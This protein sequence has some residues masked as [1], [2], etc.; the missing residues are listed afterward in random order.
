MVSTPM[1]RQQNRRLLSQLDDL[2]QDVN[3]GDGASSG[4]QNVVVNSG[5]VDKEFTVNSDDD[6]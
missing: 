1:K 5:P 6:I 3:I 2:D 4:T